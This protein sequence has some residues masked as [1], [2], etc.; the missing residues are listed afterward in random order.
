MSALQNSSPVLALTK[1][2]IQL[3]SI[4]PEDKGC[5]LLLAQRLEKL[6]F[7]LEH[8][9]FGE[10]DNLWARRGNAQPLFVFAGHTDVVP[11]GPEENWSYPPFAA[12]EHN[13]FLYGRGAADMKG[14]LAAMIIACEQFLQHF[15][16]HHGSIA[17]LLTSDEEG[18]AINGTRKVIEWL[19]NQNEQLTWCIV[20][21][22]S[23]EKYVGDSIKIGRRGS[24][25]GKL[26]IIGKQGHIAYP[27]QANN[28]IHSCLS[29]L[30]ALTN[31]IWDEGSE[32]FPPTAL[33]FS[34]IHAGAGVSNVIPNSLEVLFNFRYS[35][36][37]NA[38]ELKR[39]VVDILDAQKIRYELS[40]SLSGLPFIT[41]GGKLISAVCSVIE[42][43]QGIS[44]KLS[45]LGGTSDG[46]F[47]A[48]TGCEVVELGVCNE[49]IHQ[50]DERVSI[51]DLETLVLI[52]QEILT[53]LVTTLSPLPLAREGSK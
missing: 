24:L 16:H 40:W 10:V 38:E 37:S 41:E 49:T 53:T 15:P 22:P 47:I 48:P 27:E 28:P 25:N 30:T 31:T 9:R 21:E 18:A 2:L 19:Q 4:T 20:G 1:Q 5:Q 7:T 42:K 14:N 17:F 43:M 36:K 29:A 35:P 13:G 26:K 33:Q 23:S 12:I 11:P 51:A 52:Y 46:R 44:P 32:Q 3:P 39:R 50:A 34:N 8:L 6:G 45:T